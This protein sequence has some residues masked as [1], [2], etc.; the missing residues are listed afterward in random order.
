MFWQLLPIL[1]Q[2]T[3]WDLTIPYNNYL[4]LFC[5]NVNCC[6]VN[7]KLFNITTHLSSFDKVNKNK[8]HLPACISLRNIYSTDLFLSSSGRLGNSTDLLRSLTE[9]ITKMKESF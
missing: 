7:T 8:F 1:E 9:A 2:A 3:A 4:V 5:L 6:Y